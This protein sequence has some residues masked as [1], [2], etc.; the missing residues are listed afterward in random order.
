M[1]A[2]TPHR[3]RQHRLR[4]L[5]LHPHHHP[6]TRLHLLR[7]ASALHPHLHRCDRHRCHR[8]LVHRPVTAQVLVLHRRPRRCI[9][10]IHHASRATQSLRWRE[11]LRPVPHRARR[12]Y[13]AAH[14]AGLDEQPRVGAL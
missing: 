11:V 13:H 7:R 2:N 5:L 1:C 12:I 8:C 14:R 6:R 9:N 10:R 4:R 3:H